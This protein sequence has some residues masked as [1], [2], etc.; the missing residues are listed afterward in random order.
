VREYLAAHAPVD[1]EMAR[2]A[3]GSAMPSGDEGRAAFFAIWSMLRYE[4]ADA[5][6]SE[7]KTE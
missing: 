4:Y 1:Y 6:L 7:G 5:M 2:H 3:Y